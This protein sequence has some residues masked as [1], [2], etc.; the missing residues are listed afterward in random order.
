MNILKY[1]VPTLI[2]ALGITLSSLPSYGKPQ[3]SK[4]EK[5][6]CVTCHVSA[7]SKELNAVGKCYGEKKQLKVCAEKK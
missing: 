7:K 6:G 3:Y 1:V 4:T 5:T 2:A